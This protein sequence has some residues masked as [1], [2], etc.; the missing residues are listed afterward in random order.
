MPGLLAAAVGI[1]AGLG[2]AA[3]KVEVRA[4]RN[5]ESAYLKTAAEIEEAPRRKRRR[6]PRDPAGPA[7]DRL[8]RSVGARPRRIENASRLKR[9]FLELD[10]LD[11]RITQL[12]ALD[13]RIFALEEKIR[14]GQDR[15]ANT[16]E[17]QR[18]F[19]ER[20]ELERG[21]TED[22]VRVLHLG[23]SH[24]AADYITRTV[25]TRFQAR[26]G[27]GGRGFV[28]A[29]Q[30]ARFG[31]RRLGRP[32][33]DR[34]R[35]VDGQAKR[36]YGVAA[37]TLVSAREGAEL[38]Y[39]L[40][41]DDRYVVVHHRVQP[42]RPDV[43]VSAD[44]LDL[45]VIPGAGPED[46]TRAVRVDVSLPPPRPDAVSLVSEGAGAEIFGLSF[47]SDTPGLMYDAI[48]PVGA[49]ATLWS[50][51]E[52]DSFRSA[53]ESLAPAVFV[54][55][56]G[57]NDALAIRKGRRKLEDFEADLSALVRRLRA[58]APQADCLVFGP[59]DAAERR[60]GTLR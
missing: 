28:H 30:K 44:G 1:G 53:V 5:R 27:S 8:A 33:W 38:K 22:N 35:A 14:A 57:G 50:Q 48:G 59:M 45:S 3:E 21:A 2:C 32:G 60:G 40:T 41:E 13:A 58:A 16:I 20:T 17:K 47:E 52:A 26:F 11:E 23:D 10:R 7:F 31:G 19:R 24:I 18:L 46:Q 15:D 4:R 56:L 54:I 9:F 43:H 37:V 39:V 12:E 55:M 49:D 6:P 29:D 36:P 25:R 42:D 34:V 51:L